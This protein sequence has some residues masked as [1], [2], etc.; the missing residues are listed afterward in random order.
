MKDINLKKQI[1][2]TLND[3]QVL[4]CGTCIYNFIVPRAEDGCYDVLECPVRNLLKKLNAG[5]LRGGR[6]I[7]EQHKSM[8][9]VEAQPENYLR[10]IENLEVER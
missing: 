8:G 4:K 7:R 10:R 9:L 1:P 2:E 3:C 5:N 6:M